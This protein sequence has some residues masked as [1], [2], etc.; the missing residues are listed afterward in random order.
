MKTIYFLTIIFLLTLPNIKAQCTHP[1]YAGLMELYSSTG[2]A[3]WTNNTGWK[4]GAAGINCEPCNGWFGIKCNQLN[5]VIE[6]SLIDNQLTGTIPNLLNISQLQTF[7][8]SFNQISGGIPDFSKLPN[9]R[10][11]FCA[12]NQLEG[13]IPNFTNLPNLNE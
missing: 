8:I 11:F 12:N 2:G 6:I 1:D 10:T 7:R 4:E 5:R 13:S 9:M 3:N